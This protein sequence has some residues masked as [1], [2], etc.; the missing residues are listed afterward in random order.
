MRG[1]PLLALPLLL[2]CTEPTA[3]TVDCQ[4]ELEVTIR[5]THQG[6][7]TTVACVFPPVPPDTVYLPPP[8]DDEHDP[9]HDH[10]DHHH[11]RGHR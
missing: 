7:D 3:P 11:P 9:H 6:S 1:L 5:V 10:R 4:G 2:A 8:D